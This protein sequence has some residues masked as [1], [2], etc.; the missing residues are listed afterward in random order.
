[1][2]EGRERK[3]IGCDGRTGRGEQKGWRNRYETGSDG[4]DERKSGGRGEEGHP[5]GKGEEQERRGQGTTKEGKGREEK[6]SVKLGIIMQFLPR[7]Y[8]FSFS[9]SSFPV[10]RKDFSSMELTD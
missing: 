3:R 4:R 8:A 9:S 10:S 6:E 5:I 7:V 1:M 2:K